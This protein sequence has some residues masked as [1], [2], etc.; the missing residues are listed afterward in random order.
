VGS[1][2]VTQP[3]PQAR[4]TVETG[5][6]T[7]DR[8][9]PVPADS[10]LPAPGVEVPVRVCDLLAYQLSTRDGLPA[11]EVCWAAAEKDRAMAGLEALLRRYGHRFRPVPGSW[12]EPSI[13]LHLPRRT[14]PATAAEVDAGEAIFALDPT[15]P[16]RVV[17]LPEHPQ[18][19]AHKAPG[20]RE[21]WG[22]ILQAEEVQEEDGTWH[23]YYG[24]V[25]GY[26]LGQVAASE[27]ELP[28]GRR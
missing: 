13:R 10:R 12:N 28:P 25:G 22:W 4:V 14:A 16:R 8:G 2:R 21:V 9:S 11:F 3:G 20:R 6:G 27:I 1:A 7:T 15:R 24:F 17:Q 19:A 23:C 26:E 5:R 18:R